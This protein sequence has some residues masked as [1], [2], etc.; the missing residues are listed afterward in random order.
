MS[1]GAPSLARAIGALQRMSEELGE[2]LLEASLTVS[3]AESLTGGWISAALTA[4][5]GSSGYFMGSIC[6]YSNHVKTGLLGVSRE[7]L[8]AH[9]AVSAQCAKEMARGVRAKLGTDL[10]ISSTGIAGPSGGSPEKPIGLVYLAVLDTARS[11]T[12]ERRFQGDRRSITWGA[13]MEA[14]RLLGEFLGG[15]EG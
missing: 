13:A 1:S 7:T 6:A 14:L 8:A 3:A 11:L 5:A 2:R 12:V 15:R 4:A 9:G 10:A